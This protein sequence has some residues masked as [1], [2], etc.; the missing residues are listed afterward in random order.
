M[1]G[2]T[3]FNV[4]MITVM[5][6]LLLI[7]S[8]NN[9]F[10]QE[11]DTKSDPG[12]DSL[13]R[14]LVNDFLVVCNSGNRE[15]MESFISNSYDQNI[16]KRIP[17]FAVVSLNM[18]LYYESGGLGY[19]L[20]DIQ[21]LTPDNISFILHNKLTEVKIHLKIPVST[22][23][24]PKI[25]GF[26]KS[27]PINDS[28]QIK[29]FNESELLKRFDIS[30]QRLQKD[31][32]FSGTV[33]MA[34][35]GEPIVSKSIGNAN[36]DFTIPNQTDTKFNIASVGKLFTSI[37]ILQLA[38]KGLLSLDDPISDYVPSD[39]LDTTI[40]KKI[41]IK[42]LLTHTSGLGDYFK[43]AYK[44]WDVPVFREINDYKSLIADDVLL[45]EP[46]S[47]FSYSNTGFILLGVII[48]NVTND[49]Y[50]DYLKENIFEPTGMYN[51]DGYDKDYAVI[52]RATG[53]T[54]VYENNLIRWNNHQFTRI[55][56]GSP[57]G[58]IYSTAEDLLLFA[59]AIDSNKLLPSDYDDFLMEGKPELNVSFHSYA[60][61]ISTGAAGR[62]ASHKGDGRGTNCHFIMYLDSGYTIIILSNY[63]A[64]SANIVEN[65]IEQLMMNL[66]A[67]I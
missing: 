62:I 58:G 44:Q 17:L 18:S 29:K 43:K 48:E 9:A 64:P 33:I 51:T 59:N 35:D 57:S 32:E 45:F 30:L 14:I 36:K 1:K 2:L 54:K 27:E 5:V 65:I 47:K 11:I 42:H 34:K 13:A 15:A 60:F 49:S 21:T 23:T 6:L 10:S 52:N 53:Y 41:Q 16:I 38:E 3:L 4:K 56:R 24:P 22:T 39:W 25:V 63:S 31:E 37:A 67:K 20:I 19:D 61:F 28:S 46:G 8:P 50:F 66:S 55:V 12:N 26:I 40:S 7:L